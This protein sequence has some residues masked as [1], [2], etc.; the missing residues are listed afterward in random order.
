MRKPYQKSICTRAGNLRA[1][2]K[3]E[4]EATTVARMTEVENFI[5]L[6]VRVMCLDC[7]QIEQIRK[8][9]KEGSGTTAEA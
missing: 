4:A 6:L 2:T 9:H 1:G 5:L 3:A 7:E 8:E